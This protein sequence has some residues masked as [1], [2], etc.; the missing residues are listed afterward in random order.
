LTHGGLCCINDTSSNSFII[1]YLSSKIM[2]LVIGK[3]PLVSDK[4]SDFGVFVVLRNNLDEFG[5]VPRVPFTYAHGEC[6]DGLV[7]LVEDGDGLNDMIV[8][9]LDGEL[10]LGSGVG[11]TKTQ[12]CSAC[13]AFSELLQELF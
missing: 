7:E 8:V 5:E 10:D 9:L 11:M 2:E 4:E 12:L 1:V 6:V 3:S 13:V